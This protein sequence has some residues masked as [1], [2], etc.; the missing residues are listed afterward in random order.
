MALTR[1]AGRGGR[2]AARHA[3]AALHFENERVGLTPG[4]PLRTASDS[5]WLASVGGRFAGR[6]TFDT[7]MQYNPREARTERYGASLR[8]SPE[9]A[10]VLNA[11]YRFQRDVLRQVDLS[12]QWPVKAGWYAIGRYNYSLRDQQLLE[13]IGGIEY[14]GG[15]W[16]FRGGYQRLAAATKVIPPRCFCSSSSTVRPRS[17][18]T[19]RVNLLRRT[20][21]GIR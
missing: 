7:T 2:S 16:V 19:T 12:A 10:K 11:G 3:G 18:R 13:G 20:V 9:I 21:P 15:C 6:W 4:A 8:F 5:D 14:N 1:A 17:A